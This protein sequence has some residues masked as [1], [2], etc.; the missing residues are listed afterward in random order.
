MGMARTA[1][2][3]ETGLVGHIAQM[4]FVSDASWDADRERRFV[5][6]AWSALGLRPFVLIK[7]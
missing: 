5:D 1:A 7:N 4:L 3:D 6:L 2:T